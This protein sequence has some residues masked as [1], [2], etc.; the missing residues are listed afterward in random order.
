M[1]AT[2]EEIE[3]AEGKKLEQQLYAREA[4]L[5]QECQMEKV[6]EESKK[7]KLVA[8]GNSKLCDIKPFV[9]HKNQLF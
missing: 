3:A 7:L 8:E 4:L 9:M 5:Y 6:V 2:L 1:V